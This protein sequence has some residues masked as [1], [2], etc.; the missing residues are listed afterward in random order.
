MSHAAGGNSPV[1]PAKKLPMFT[2]HSSP[3][4]T[5][6]Q[7]HEAFGQILYAS[8]DYVPGKGKKDGSKKTKIN[9]LNAHVINGVIFFFDKAAE[10]INMKCPAFRDSKPKATTISWFTL[11][12]MWKQKLEYRIKQRL[13]WG[14]GPNAFHETG[15]GDFP[16]NGFEAE[17]DSNFDRAFVNAQ[18]DDIL[19]THLMNLSEQEQSRRTGDGAEAAVD[20]ALTGVNSQAL[21]LFGSAPAQ[22]GFGKP[23]NPPARDGAVAGSSL[24][25]LSQQTGTAVT[26]RINSKDTNLEKSLQFGDSVMSLGEKMVAAIQPPTLEAL[27]ERSKA[28]AVAYAGVFKEAVAEGIREWKNPPARSQQFLSMTTSDVIQKIKQIGTLFSN[29]STFEAQLIACGI[30]GATL[31]CMGDVDLKDFFE[32]QCAFQPYQAAI[33]VASIKSWQL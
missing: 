33:L 20:H 24:K 30:N 32:K 7:V 29:N 23:M 9:I 27:G 16:L 2:D 31:S 3:Q 10:L 26:K 15:D 11:R 8:F 22:T 12:A 5:L 28:S 6:D 13:S 25:R 18:I 1:T 17:R 21:V 19:D 14:K 4:W